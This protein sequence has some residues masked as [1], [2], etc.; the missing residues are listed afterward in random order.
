MFNI[1]VIRNSKSVIYPDYYCLPSL[2]PYMHIEIVIYCC[3]PLLCYVMLCYDYFDFM[4]QIT[5]TKCCVFKVAKYMN[6]S[7]VFLFKHNTVV[8]IIFINIRRVLDFVVGLTLKIK[9]QRIGNLR[10]IILAKIQNQLNKTP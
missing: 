2:Y 4:V 1:I 3:F 9:N 8:L 10:K 7:H 6:P 5:L